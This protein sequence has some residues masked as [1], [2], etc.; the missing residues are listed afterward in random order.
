MIL[1]HRPVKADDVKT[2]CRFPLNAQELFYM[3]PKA[4]YPLTETQLFNAITQRFDST[5]VETDDGIVGFANFYRAET[6]GVCCIGN[7]IVAQEARGQ[8]VATF[9]VET[10]TALAFDRYNA[11]QV[12]ISCFNENT[13][14][15]L[16]YPKLGFLPFAIEERLSADSRRTALIHMSRA[17]DS[18]SICTLLKT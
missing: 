11:T 18:L 7:V 15:L 10:M 12:Q 6:G 3:F 14:G 1:R 8:G 16:L 17:R 4:Q 5:I 9:L 2:I 13:A